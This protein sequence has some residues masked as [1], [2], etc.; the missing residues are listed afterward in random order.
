MKKTKILAAVMVCAMTAA[1]AGCG[2]NNTASTTTAAAATTTTAAETTTT[3][4]AETTAETTEETTTT[5][6]E[7]TAEEAP[8]EMTA[9]LFSRGV[10]E[11]Y[12][13]DILDSYFV[14]YDE[15]SG[16]IIG[17]EHIEQVPFTCE[18]NGAEIMFHLGS[19]DNNT[20]AVFDLGDVTGTFQ[21]SED[22]KVYRFAAL[23][24]DVNEF[25]E[26]HGFIV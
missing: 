12:D 1:A 19:D 8:M 2:G 23:D 4:A 9:P 5:E 20:P 25:L 24:T 7:T 16:M 21:F 17:V 6:A 11:T 26:T 13:G 15:T 3:T 22:Q 10:W 18:Q 14:F